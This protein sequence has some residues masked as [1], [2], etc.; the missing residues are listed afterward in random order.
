MSARPSLTV[1]RLSIV[2]VEGRAAALPLPFGDPL[3]AGRR[4]RA[5][6][7]AAGAALLPALAHGL[8]AVAVVDALTDGA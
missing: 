1:V 4:A 3:R 2:L 5:Q 6:Y 8:H 7:R